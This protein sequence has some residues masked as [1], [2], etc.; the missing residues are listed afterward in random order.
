M[1]KSVFRRKI[2]DEILEWFQ[3][4]KSEKGR[5]RGLGLY[6]L[7]CLCNDWNCDI[8][9]GNTEIDK[10][11][12]N[13]CLELNKELAKTMGVPADSMPVQSLTF[14]IRTNPDFK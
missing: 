3:L 2:Y 9:C 4:E 6:H 13:S 1:S 10:N 14:S 7:K 5:G 11:N 8:Q 12:W